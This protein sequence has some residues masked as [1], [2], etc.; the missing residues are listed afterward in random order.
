MRRGLALPGDG[1]HAIS[2]I[3]CLS[4]AGALAAYVWAVFVA[5]LARSHDWS[6]HTCRLAGYPLLAFAVWGVVAGRPGGAVLD[7]GTWLLAAECTGRL[8]RYIAYP[9]LGWKDP[10]K[11]APKKP[12]QGPRAIG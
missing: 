4:L 6:P 7:I 5:A 9:E 8:C 1:A 2:R 3:I 12:P 11:G 10:P